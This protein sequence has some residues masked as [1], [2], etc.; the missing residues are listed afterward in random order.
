MP[1]LFRRLALGVV[2]SVCS[3]AGAARAKCGL[4]ARCDGKATVSQSDADWERKL[5]REE[6]ECA[7]APESVRQSQLLRAYEQA[8]QQ[9]GTS[10]TA[11]AARVWLGFA[12]LQA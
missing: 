3:A 1:R 4:A 9:I 8:T 5:R 6:A 7:D 10:H 11:E 2:S 12:K